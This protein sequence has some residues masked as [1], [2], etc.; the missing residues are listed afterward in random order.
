MIL[1]IITILTIVFLYYMFLP[2]RNM[3]DNEA[4]QK[5]LKMFE[6]QTNMLMQF[7]ASREMTFDLALDNKVIADTAYK[8]RIKECYQYVM[9]NISSYIYNETL[10]YLSK[11]EIEQNLLIRVEALLFESYQGKIVN[12]TEVLNEVEVLRD[13]TNKMNQQIQREMNRR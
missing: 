1:L 7:Y 6:D 9:K 11:D 4:Y 10:L 3:K 8:E 12:D 5:A 13:A 2:W